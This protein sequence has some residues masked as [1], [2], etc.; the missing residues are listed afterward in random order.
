MTPAPRRLSKILSCQTNRYQWVIYLA[1]ACI[2]ATLAVKHHF[3]MNR[4]QQE[5]IAGLQAENAVVAER[6]NNR[7]GNIHQ[8]MHTM[9]HLPGIAFAIKNKGVLE[10]DYERV[11]QEL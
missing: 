9:A 5:F 8:G 6:I 1:G 11:L 2:A 10:K 4:L 3:D 7:L